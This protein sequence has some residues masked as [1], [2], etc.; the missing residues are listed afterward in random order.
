MR[1][2]LAAL[3][4]AGAAGAAAAQTVAPPVEIEAADEA[5]AQPGATL[6]TTISQSVEA[7]TNYGLDDPSPG[8]S[9]Y[10]DSRVALD[11]LN[12]S[13]TQ[14]FALGIDTGLR[15]LWEAGQDFEV[16]AASP[17][18]AYFTYNQ[19]GV[20]TVFDADLR[21][22]TRLVNAT[23]RIDVLEPDQGPVADPLD[24]GNVDTR[25]QRYD[26]DIGFVLGATSP[27][28]YEFRLLG[29]A[30]DYE[31]EEGTRLAPN[32]SVEGQA[33]WTLQFTPVFSTALFG[34]YFYYTADDDQDTELNIAEAEAGLVYH[35]SEN[36]RIRG[37]LGYADRH[38]EGT[39]PA[40]GERETLQDN[41]G[42]TAR[43]DI[44]Y[45]IPSF[46]LLGNARWSAAAPTNRLS[47]NL[48][49]VYTLARGQVSGRV[50]QNYTGNNQGEEQRVTG[51]GIGL[52]RDINTISRVGLDFDYATQVNL[53][54][55]TEP[56]IDRTDLTLSYGYDFTPAITGEVGYTFRNRIE[57]PEDADS[58]RVYFVIGREFVTGL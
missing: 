11:Y 30:F 46:V 8:T 22:R 13:P 23:T 9:Y 12:Q 21:A 26:A 42:L 28:T 27:S 16:V 33:L 29:T 31:N 51:A 7:D 24:Q 50:F 17:S 45:I 44:R 10:G 49:A 54:D 38:R 14:V 34:S 39:D 19:E 56:D 6:T 15:P 48:A 57:D 47:G 35:P 3:T 40:T 53:D 20:D 25:E 41:Q 43:A 18:T 2:V 55:P 58:H 37:G 32:R 36:F 5:E 1:R 4:L 52:T